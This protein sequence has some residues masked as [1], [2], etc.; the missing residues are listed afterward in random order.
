[1]PGRF[2]LVRD[3]SELAKTV[4]VPMPDAEPPRSNIQ[5]G[6]DILVLT[7]NGFQKMRWGMIP[8][9]RKNARGRPVMET[10]INARSETVFDKSAFDDL[11]RAVVPVDGWYEWTG[12]TR[13][14]TVWDIRPKDGS[15][16]WFAAIFDVW[17]GPGGI[18][19]PQ[20]ATLTCPPNGDLRGI[21]DRMGVV[22]APDTVDDWLTGDEEAARA[23]FRPWLNGRLLITD[24][25]DVDWAKP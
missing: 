17:H 1:M 4:S 19:V 15:P 18:N 16:L 21:H 2:Y 6:Q 7:A 10:I 9:G 14:K 5:P 22:L 12:Q 23:L 24:A 11:R 13:H 3:T 20:V 25:K 8:T